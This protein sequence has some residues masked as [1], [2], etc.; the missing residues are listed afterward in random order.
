VAFVKPGGALVYIT[1]SV[2]PD[3]NAHQA[4]A[5]LERHPDFAAVPG[6]TLW[7]KHFAGGAARARFSPEGGILLSPLSTGTDGF[8]LFMAQRA[9]G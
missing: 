5:F 7:M 3:E 2:L 4:K 8:Y 9:A 6:N 1:C